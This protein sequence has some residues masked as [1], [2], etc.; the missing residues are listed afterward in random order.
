MKLRKLSELKL[1]HKRYIIIIFLKQLMFI[2]KNIYGV[3]N[4]IC[5][6]GS[7]R[8]PLR[9][10]GHSYFSFMYILAC[11]FVAISGLQLYQW[12]HLIHR[13]STF[14]TISNMHHNR[15]EKRLKCIIKEHAFLRSTALGDQQQ[16]IIFLIK[17]LYCQ[18]SPVQCTSVVV[19]PYGDL[20]C[21]FQGFKCS[22]RYYFSSILLGLF[23]IF[24]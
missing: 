23:Y 18:A 22:N 17:I 11:L 2:F 12:N 16:P 8:W 24:I 6:P 7:N 9:G 10:E 14:H 15:Q 4:L 21:V 19:L 20:C 1:K 3:R 5:F 13:K